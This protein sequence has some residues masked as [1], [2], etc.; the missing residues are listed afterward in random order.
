MVIGVQADEFYVRGN[1]PKEVWVKRGSIIGK[2]PAGEKNAA[3]GVKSTLG[4][5]PPG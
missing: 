4:P 3:V 5:T 2:E 1:V